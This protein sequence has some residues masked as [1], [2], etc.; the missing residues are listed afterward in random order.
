MAGAIAGIFLPIYIYQWGGLKAVAVLVAQVV[1][2]DS[3]WKQK[4][5]GGE[6]GV[7]VVGRKDFVDIGTLDDSGDV[8]RKLANTYPFSPST[9]RS[10]L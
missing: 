10:P 7:I 5:N 2:Y 9:A 3:S 6:G 1:D 8:E 4:R